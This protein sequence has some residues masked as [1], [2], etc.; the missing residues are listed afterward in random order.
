MQLVTAN[1]AFLLTALQSAAIWAIVTLGQTARETTWQHCFALAPLAVTLS[2]SV[3]T[4]GR[5]AQPVPP[6]SVHL[7]PKGSVDGNHPGK[8]TPQRRVPRL[9]VE[10]SPDGQV[11]GRL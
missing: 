6:S 2:V 8:V 10:D 3:V 9:T 4:P 7:V 5:L 11:N 1:H